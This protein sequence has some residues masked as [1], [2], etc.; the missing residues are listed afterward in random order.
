MLEILAEV[1]AELLGGLIPRRFGIAILALF[2][3][4]AAAGC[5]GVGGW[6]VY[7]AVVED[8]ERALAL[9][10]LLAW[11]MGWALALIGRKLVSE[12]R[13]A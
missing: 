1:L 7:R 3:F 5:F 12:H 8:T 9:V 13:E 10:A 6:M 2:F 11:T 4:A